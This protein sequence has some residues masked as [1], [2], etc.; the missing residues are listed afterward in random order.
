MLRSFLSL[1]DLYLH[2][3]LL[4]CIVIVSFHSNSTRVC[5]YVLI[6]VLSLCSYFIPI[7]NCYFYSRSPRLIWSCKVLPYM[8]PHVPCPSQSRVMSPNPKCQM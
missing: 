1:K 4:I 8:A 7:N 3:S 5:L 2:I 6:L